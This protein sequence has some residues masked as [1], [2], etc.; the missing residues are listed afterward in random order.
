MT[1]DSTPLLL[2]RNP[3]NSHEDDNNYVE[4]RG[5]TCE[6]KQKRKKQI[7]L[8][9]IV[10]FVSLAAVFVCWATCGDRMDSTP[11]QAHPSNAIYWDQQFIAWEEWKHQR[12]LAEKGDNQLAAHFQTPW[13]LENF[14]NRNTNNDVSQYDQIL[15]QKFILWWESAHDYERDFWDLTIDEMNVSSW[16]ASIPK[17]SQDMPW[18][19]AS[20]KLMEKQKTEKKQDI[21][22]LT[23][24]QGSKM[25]SPNFAAKRLIEYQPGCDTQV[26]EAY[27]AVASAAAVLNLLRASFL[28]S[29]YTYKTQYGILADRCVQ[30]KVTHTNDLDP[31]LAAGLGMQQT[32]VL[33]ECLLVGQKYDANAYFVEPFLKDRAD[34][35]KDRIYSLKQL[36]QTMLS[37]MGKGKAVLI[38]YDRSVLGQE[39]H[40]HWSPVVAYDSKTCS[41]LVLDVARY[42]YEPVWVPSKTLFRALAEVDACGSFSYETSGNADRSH[43]QMAADLNCEQSHRGIIVLE[44]AK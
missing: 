4:E 21:T 42:K 17:E 14:W 39:G 34:I 29:G 23:S 8:Y 18:W 12:A 37:S 6:R 27:S 1:A 40:G 22:Y 36:K 26:N 41:F 13:L 38:N 35:S 7:Q 25:L 2:R 44:K 3:R 19:N 11:L 5:F 30:Q 31:K 15:G 33:L 32:Q 16:F 20:R 43:T 10:N 24:L 9:P 28:S